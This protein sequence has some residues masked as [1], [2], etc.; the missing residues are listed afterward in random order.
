MNEQL[1]L[2]RELT[3]IKNPVMTFAITSGKGGVGKTVLSILISAFISEKGYRVLLFDGDVGLANVNVMLG[4]F[5]DK[6]FYHL[7]KGEATIDEVIVDTPLG[8]K[9]L[10]AGSGIRDLLDMDY[11]MRKRAALEFAKLDGL[12]DYIVV[13]T[14][15]GIG[16]EVFLFTLSSQEVI[17]VVTPEPTSVVDAYSL[18]K[19]L[20]KEFGKMKVNVIVNKSADTLPYDMLARLIESFLPNVRLELIGVVP[21]LERVGLMVL[22]QDFSSLDM[23]KEKVLPLVDKMLDELSF[24]RVS[25]ALSRFSLGFLRYRIKRGDYVV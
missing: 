21:E 5:P 19:I 25:S 7:V 24:P 14:A 20:Y 6:N 22:S 12:F 8:F 4:I 13:D 11:D 16:D 2:L 9:L 10:P 18:V 17:L 23:V 1:L 3:G 15:A